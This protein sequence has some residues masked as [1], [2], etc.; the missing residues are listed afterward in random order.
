VFASS[1]PLTVAVP[2]V[3]AARRN[4]IPMVFEVRDLWPDVPIAMGALRTPFSR[5]AAR[6]LERQA[7]RNAARIV[8]LSPAMKEGIVRVGYPASQ[9]TV[10]PNACDV[11]LFDVAPAVGEDLR[12]QHPW[13]GGRRLVIYTGTLGMANGVSYLA[14]LAAEVQRRDPSVVFVVIG[15][16]KEAPLVRQAAAS[17]GVL[18]RNFYLLAPQ[19]KLAM[20]AWFSAADLVTSMFID[21]RELWANS[22]NKV[23]DGFAAGRPVVINH[24]GWIADLLRESGAGLVL[25]AHDMAAAAT[26]LIRALGDR[27]WMARARTSARE[28]AR[29]RFN[30]QRLGGELE[31]V[32]RDVVQARQPQSL[33]PLVRESGGMLK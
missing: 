27:P 23:F 21:V 15:K 7:Y 2:G 13:L 32:L 26:A 31:Q 24:E 9:V 3:Y 14:R 30:R 33:P 8:A 17:L 25:D 5:G 29:S 16:G 18:D 22:A 11:S 1:T 19:P 12:R 28:L 20:P 6:W 4:R 10:I